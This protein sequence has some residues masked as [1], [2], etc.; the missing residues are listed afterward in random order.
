MRED[1]CVLGCVCACTSRPAS[2]TPI[3]RY[4]P[5][6]SIDPTHTTRQTPRDYRLRVILCLVDAEDS[7]GPL[8][9]IN[10]MALVEEC[11]LLLAWSTPEA[12]R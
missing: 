12:A 7:A 5:L 4:D 8:L 6:N 10:R 2:R 9:E 11:T 1:G 3:C